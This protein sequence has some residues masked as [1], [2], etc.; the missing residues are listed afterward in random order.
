MLK[1]IRHV[2]IV[3]EDFEDSLKFYT[4]ILG[5][6]VL[7]REQLKGEYPLKLFN[8]SMDFEYIK[9]A[10][11]NNPSDV[12]ELYLFNDRLFIPNW[13][14]NHIAFTI[15]NA[16]ELFDKFRE[17]K[18]YCLSQEPISNPENTCKLFFAVDPSGNILE[19]VEVLK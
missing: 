18:I 11:D 17:N 6:T 4:E 15:E 8:E 16:D 9:L 14:Y 19:F 5:M 12:V 3:V 10:I 2:G 7:I 13:S 1:C